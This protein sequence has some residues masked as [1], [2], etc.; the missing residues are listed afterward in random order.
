VIGL[1]PEQE[2]V[3]ITRLQQNGFEDVHSFTAERSKKIYV[4]GRLN[5]NLNKNTSAIFNDMPGLKLEAR[6]QENQ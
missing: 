5:D 2:N 6:N 3:A 1:K 4:V